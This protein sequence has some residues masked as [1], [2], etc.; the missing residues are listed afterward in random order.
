MRILV[1][2]GC[3]FLGSHVVDHFMKGTDADI[4]VLDKLTYASSGYDRLRDSEAYDSA[5]TT[6]L[7]ADFRQPLAPGVCQEIGAVDYILHLG[8]E[9]HV[10]RSIAD[11]TPFT[12]SNVLGTQ[13]MLE[14]ARTVPSLRLMLYASTD[15]VYGVAPPGLNYTE[16]DRRDPRNTYESTKAAA[17]MLCLAYAHTYGVPVVITNTMNLV[18]ERQ[19]SE[20]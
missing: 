15:E 12:L 5:R 3:G 19:H 8:G 10:D 20:K 1:T 11:C 18:G 9:T 7:A 13:M 16:A 4:V 2:G 17:E 14:F 6:I